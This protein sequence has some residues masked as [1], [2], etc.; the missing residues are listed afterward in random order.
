MSSTSEQRLIPALAEALGQY[1]HVLEHVDPGCKGCKVLAD[2]LRDLVRYEVSFADALRQARDESKRARRAFENA[3]RAAFPAEIATI[4]GNRRD[5]GLAAMSPEALGNLTVELVRELTEKHWDAEDQHAKER[6]SAHEERYKQLEQELR[7]TKALLEQ[8]EK[9]AVK[10]TS[11]ADRLHQA[12]PEIPSGLFDALLEAHMDLPTM[13]LF[14]ASEK[15]ELEFKV[16]D[17]LVSVVVKHPGA[18]DPPAETRARKRQEIPN[19]PPPQPKAEPGHQE[20]VAPAAAPLPPEEPAPPRP[21][22]AT[23]MTAERIRQELA[24]AMSTMSL[25]SLERLKAASAGLAVPLE[26]ALKELTTTRLVEVVPSMDGD[27][28]ILP[29]DGFAKLVESVTV[30]PM[31]THPLWISL[32]K[33]IRTSKERQLVAEALCPFLARDWELVMI[34]RPPKGGACW[35]TLSGAF[36]RPAVGLLGVLLDAPPYTIPS[37][38]PNC[39]TLWIVG[40]EEQLQALPDLTAGPD[41]WFGPPRRSGDDASWKP[42]RQSRATTMR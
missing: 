18:S 19:K 26:R 3:L 15:G 40:D 29:N 14:A 33:Q 39:S 17:T 20:M 31:V 27:G 41:V 6:I 38:P 24:E 16:D 28:L 1:K 34:W 11:L 21:T 5:G 13:L 12:T 32:G 42:I 4:E 35:L 23:T 22:G 7:Q 37:Y 8:A 2:A 10:T 36:E 25:F 30:E 9:R